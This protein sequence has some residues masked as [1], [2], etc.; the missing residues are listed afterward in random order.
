MSGLLVVSEYIL[1]LG[2]IVSFLLF[3]IAPFNEEFCILN[4][5]QRFLDASSIWRLERERCRSFGILE[6]W[7]NAFIT[8]LQIVACNVNRL[9]SAV[10]SIFDRFRS[11]PRRNI[12]W[13]APSDF[14]AQRGNWQLPRPPSSDRSNQDSPS[15]LT[16]AILF[17]NFDFLVF[18]FST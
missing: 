9:F 15:R 6:H 17:G 1:F 18:N 13:V 14:W 7:I 4:C 3:G 12:E 16:T 10:R 5:G 8:I 2:S 11:F